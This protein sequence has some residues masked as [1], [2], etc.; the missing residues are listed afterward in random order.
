MSGAAASEAEPL[1]KCTLSVLACQFLQ[2]LAVLMPWG[3][4]TLSSAVGYNSTVEPV[5]GPSS[6]CP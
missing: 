4:A 2:R 5:P 1:L 6:R 3:P